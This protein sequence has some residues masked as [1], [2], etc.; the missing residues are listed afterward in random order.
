MRPFALSVVLA[1]SAVGCFAEDYFCRK[2]PCPPVAPELCEGPCAPYVGGVWSAVLV[3]SA[4]TVPPPCPVQVAPF[5][6]M[7]SAAP[8]VRACGV[9]GDDGA[10]SAPGFVCLPPVPP[11][12]VVCVLRDGSHVCP[13]PYPAAVEVD[14]GVTVCCL[15]PSGDPG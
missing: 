15:S 7:S 5:E 13:A 6:T 3:A 11:P 14:S 9:Q 4:D 1:A 8:P 10:C 12:W 2:E